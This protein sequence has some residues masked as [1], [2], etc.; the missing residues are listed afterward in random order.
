MQS[1]WLSCPL[2]VLLLSLFAAP[3]IAQETPAAD[4]NT[5]VMHA[6]TEQKKAKDER[7]EIDDQTKHRIMFYM[8]VPLVIFLLITVILG[9]GMVVFRKPYFVAH[10][11]FA[12]FSLTLALA[13]AVVGVVW[14]NPF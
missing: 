7:L 14:F 8:G 9:I 3:A 1:R 5:Q 6:F 2:L 4:N 11:I 12:G 13:H 10:M